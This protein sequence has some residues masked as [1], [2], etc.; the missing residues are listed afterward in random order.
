[1]SVKISVGKFVSKVTD[2]LK[3]RIT[4]LAAT[5]AIEFVANRINE[6]TTI[7]GQPMLTGIGEPGTVA[8]YTDAYERW[9][10]GGVRARIKKRSDRKTRLPPKWGKGRAVYTPGDRFVLSGNMMRAWQVLETSVN[11]M[12]IGFTNIKEALK[13][14]ANHLRRP[15]FALSRDE[16][17]KLLDS[18]LKEVGLKKD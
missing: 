18:V 11:R 9:K 5:A 16:A 12:R 7:D 2:E 1:M 17:K 14:L 4:T 15:T 3:L 10:T 6:G 8:R 13:G